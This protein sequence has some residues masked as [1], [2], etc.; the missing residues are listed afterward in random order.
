MKK[1]GLTLKSSLIIFAIVISILSC[2]M[3]TKHYHDGKYSMKSM[4]LPMEITV[5]LDGSN[6]TVH[7]SM[8]GITET[9][10]CQQYLYRVVIS[11]GFGKTQTLRVLEDGSLYINDY[12][13]FKKVKQKN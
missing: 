4:I 12:G 2:E 10:K 8:T 5:T 7:N 6:W 13:S 3:N 1:I 11:R 9:F